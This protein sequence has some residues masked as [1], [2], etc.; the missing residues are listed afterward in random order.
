MCLFQWIWFV[1]ISLREAIVAY[2]E[3][4]FCNWQIFY[5]ADLRVKE[6]YDSEIIAFRIHHPSCRIMNIII[7]MRLTFR[8]FRIYMYKEGKK[9]MK[10][11]KGNVRQTWFFKHKL[12]QKKKK[13]KVIFLALIYECESRNAAIIW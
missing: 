4:A 6:N 9:Q 12:L 3:K 1:S 8:C 2:F 7:W 11:R 10:K 13:K 5:L